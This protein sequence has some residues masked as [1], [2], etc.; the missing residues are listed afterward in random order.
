MKKI[1]ASFVFLF[2]ATILN[3]AD[4]VCMGNSNTNQL[5]QVA[6]DL[7]SRMGKVTVEGSTYDLAAS[8]DFMY[9]WQNEVEGQ[10]YTNSLSRIDGQLNVIAE[11][12]GEE[13]Q[14]IVRAILNCVDKKDLLF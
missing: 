8:N 3:A 5:I 10:T 1:L 11:N 13:N 9:V 6:I 4:L 2:S 12:V 7:D 14:P